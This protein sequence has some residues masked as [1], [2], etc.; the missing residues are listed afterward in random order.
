MRR[1]DRARER[2]RSALIVAAWVAV[3]GVMGGL[4]W[5]LVDV[6][7][8]NRQADSAVTERTWTD[9]S[10]NHVETTVSY[11]MSP[12][13][14]GDHASWWQNCNGDVYEPPIRNETAVHSL[15]HGSV[16]VT[17]NSKVSPAD[18]QPLADTV[19][20]TP[21]TLMSPYPDQDAPVT[22]TAWGRQL[23]VTGADDPRIQ[24][25]LSEYVQ[26]SQTPEPG[27]ACTGGLTE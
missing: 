20:G 24:Q 18:V 25:F 23:T 8:D 16:W 14:G 9:L 21:Y 13:A 27:A 4:I 6:T 19:A 5:Y 10:R 15:E 17:Y 12:P 22:L 2:C 11:P 26:G 7:R 1:A 3:A